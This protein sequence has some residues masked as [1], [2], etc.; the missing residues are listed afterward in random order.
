MLQTLREFGEAGDIV[1]VDDNPANLRLLSTVLRERGHHVRTAINARVAL[2]AISA[3]RPDL[4]ILDVSMPEISGIELCRLLREDPERI[5][6]PVIFLSALDGLD[7]KSEAFDLGGVDY[8]TKPFKPEEI[9][10][11]VRNHLALGRLQRQL[12]LT[13]REL[14]RRVEARTR[15]LSALNTI[16]STFFPHEC[17]R[18]LGKS[19]I[20]EL[21]LGD[22]VEREMTVMFADIEG[23]T[24]L[25]ESMTPVDAFTLINDYLHHVGPKIREHGGY[26]DKFIGDAIMAVF[27]HPKEAVDA[28]VALHGAL[29]ELNAGRADAG[30]VR[31]GVGIGIHHGMMSLGILGERQRMQGTVIA[32]A[33]NVAAR[34]EGLTRSYGAGILVSDAARAHLGEDSSRAYRFIDHVQLRGRREEMVVWE[35]LAPVVIPEHSA[36]VEQ[37]QTYNHALQAFGDGR[38]ADAHALFRQILDHDPHD[39]TARSYLERVA[40]RIAER[41]AG[42]QSEEV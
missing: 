41:S 14:E 42:E 20:L 8:V 22:H 16:Y 7:E 34:I 25:A 30:E 27:L 3:Q 29:R 37:L 39:R 21:R 13:N 2:S 32:D 31:L 15:R 28:A 12:E 26:I 4:V 6:L 36:R 19:D 38:W 24:A 40:R 10:L 5:N 1:I 17:L 33:V 18:L 11:R 23:F 35:A 9:L